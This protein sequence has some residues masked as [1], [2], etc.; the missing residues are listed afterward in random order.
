MQENS[1]TFPPAETADKDGL[2]AVGGDLSPQ[3][4]LAA[5]RAGVFPWF[6]EGEPYLWW[7]PNPRMVLFPEKLHISKSMHQLLNQQK[8]K[9]TVNQNF[10]EVILNCARMTRKGQQGTW[11]TNEM[12]EAY[13]H[14]HELGYAYSVEVWQDAELVGGLYGIYLK[15]KHVFCGESMFARV[16]N[17]SKYGFITFVQKLQ[18]EGVKLIDCQIY[19]P[20]LASLGAEE[21]PRE[22]FL[23]FLK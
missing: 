23:A 18:R 12:K 20:H 3:C 15:E 11:I 21:I 4:L 22:K 6:N 9:V 10:V 14:L 8:F 17:A 19:T 5:Y 13:I 1:Y 7:T 16:S 2:L